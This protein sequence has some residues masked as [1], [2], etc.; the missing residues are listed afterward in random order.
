MEFYH[1]NN[2]LLFS[3]RGETFVRLLIETLTLNSLVIC[4]KTVDLIDFLN[5][6]YFSFFKKINST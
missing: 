5:V 6:K 4:S 1:K 2:L 3:S